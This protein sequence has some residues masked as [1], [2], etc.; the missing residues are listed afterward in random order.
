[1]HLE[2]LE[3]ADHQQRRIAQILAIIV[4]L[5]VGLLQALVLDLVFPCKVVAE[6]YV[7]K[8]G[9]AARLADALFKGVALTRRISL[10]GALLAEEFAQIAEVRLRAGALG[11]RIDLPSLDKSG[12]GKGYGRMV[13]LQPRDGD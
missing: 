12:Y 4:E 6:P 9:A 1:M 5:L 2:A 8:A 3:V 7:G 10:G 11:L 13:S